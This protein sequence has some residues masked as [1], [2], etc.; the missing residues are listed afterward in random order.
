[1]IFFIPFALYYKKDSPELVYAND[2]FMRIQY[3]LFMGFLITYF[4]AV[5]LALLPIA[6]IIGI[7]F[8]VSQLKKKPND[9]KNKKVWISFVRLFLFIFLGPLVLLLDTFS[10]IY[11]FLKQMFL[12]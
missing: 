9:D 3:I 5:S 8:K 6:W 7:S 1:M 2:L 4:I 11:H 10:D 12:N